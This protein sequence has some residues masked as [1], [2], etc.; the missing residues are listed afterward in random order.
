[1]LR[2]QVFFFA[3]MFGIL[4]GGLLGCAASHHELREHESLSPIVQE[5]GAMRIAK[6]QNAAPGSFDIAQE[7]EFV[8]PIPAR[9]APK[10]FAKREAE[11]LADAGDL[12][13]WGMLIFGFL[14]LLQNR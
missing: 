1:M 4:C 14:V 3:A 6:G 9:V 11:T 8:A 7:K 10:L 5:D 2:T 12:I 13:F